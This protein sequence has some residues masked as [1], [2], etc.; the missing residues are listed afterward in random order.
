MR[1]NPSSPLLLRN[2]QKIVR[3]VSSREQQQIEQELVLYKGPI[4]YKCVPAPEEPEGFFTV[5][6]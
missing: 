3:K 4:P 2:L 6:Q 1:D 5:E